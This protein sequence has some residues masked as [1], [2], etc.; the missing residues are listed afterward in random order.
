MPTAAL[1]AHTTAG[2]DRAALVLLAFDEDVAAEVLRHLNE[3]EVKALT[4][5]AEKLPPE[6]LR[7]LDP[8]LEDFEREMRAGS[9]VSSK[10]AGAYFRGLAERA[11]G[12]ERARRM[13]A[14]PK[15]PGGPIDTIRTARIAT[16]AELLGEEHPQIA[17]VIL[18]QLPRDRA[19]NIL[20][21]I[22]PDRQVDIIGRI[23]ALKELPSQTIDVA[24]EALAKALA[25]AGALGGGDDQQELEG[26]PLAASLLN[27]LSAEESQRILTE[28]EG[29][30]EGVAPRVRQAMFTFEDLARVDKRSLPALMRDV[31]SDLLLTALKT[32]SLEVRD[33]F[34]S[35]VSSRAADTMRDEL[36]SMPPLKLSEVERAQQ[37]I[38]DCAL[39]L[40]A[41]GR[42]TLPNS[43]SETLV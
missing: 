6:V 14:P 43:S 38:V 2:R 29:T 28:L 19:A 27:E 31:S 42:M 11:L 9:P 25:S 24:S 21:A 1:P 37:E 16:V 32:A 8:T 5:C 20:R 35:A 18:S 33:H 39:R 4:E 30:Y 17:A 40:A 22:A 12:P 10:K 41:E 3:S 23:A 13:L 26:I 36:A 15:P 34:F 7:A